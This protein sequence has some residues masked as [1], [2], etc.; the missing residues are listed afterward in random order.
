MAEEQK[1]ACNRTPFETTDSCSRGGVNIREFEGFPLCEVVDPTVAKFAPPTFDTPTVPFPPPPCACVDIKVDG[2]T[3]IEARKDIYLN[4]DFKA[5]GDCCEGNYITEVD[6]KIPCIPFSIET[7]S[8]SNNVEI[9]QECELESPTGTL[10]LNITEDSCTVVFTPSLK[11]KL[12]KIPKYTFNSAE[13]EI[14]QE[15]GLE[16]P[17]GSFNF[18]IEDNSCTFDI[19]PSLKLRLPKPPTYTFNGNLDIRFECSVS[20]STTEFYFTETGSC[21][22]EVT[23][24]IMINLPCIPFEIDDGGSSTPVMITYTPSTTEPSGTLTLNIQKEC[25]ELKFAPE[26]DLTLPCMPFEIETGSTSGSNV[27]IEQEC[28]LESPTGT[29]KL[30][31]EKKSDRCAISFSPSLKLKIPK[32]K[33][34]T[35]KDPEPEIKKVGGFCT[36]FKYEFKFKDNDEN[37]HNGGGQG[38]VGGQG[39][40]N[41]CE[42]EVEPEIK[43]EYPCLPFCV[44]DPVKK[45]INIQRD[46]NLCKNPIGTAKIRV[47]TADSCTLKFTPEIDITLPRVPK[48]EACVKQQGNVNFVAAQG[49][50]PIGG[51]GTIGLDIQEDACGDRTICPDL[52]LDIPCPLEGINIVG[53][54]RIQV[55]Q[56]AGQNCTGY[57]W[58]LKF[59]D[60]PTFSPDEHSVCEGFTGTI[61]FLTGLRFTGTGFEAITGRLTYECGMCTAASAPEIEVNIPT[62]EHECKCGE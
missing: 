14:I 39:G 41:K 15:C 54:N 16:S 27:E 34:Y 35:F 26:L 12:P 46:N 29:L 9:E 17:D 55:V 49:G 52:E 1:V 5:D 8:S 61:T 11:L 37:T 57:T 62:A 51:T 50:D 6:L 59:I 3:E 36:P 18:N 31:V 10:K 60:S 7:A 28:D 23:A 44:A 53:D 42:Q 22:K 32:Q 40:D 25:C 19:T 33:K 43:I 30:N 45:S 47:D 21:D 4:V 13:V 58:N 2:K 24:N 20:S 56:E 48:L 38:G